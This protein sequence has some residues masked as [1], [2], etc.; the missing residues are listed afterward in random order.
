MKNNESF[1]YTYSAKEQ[2][3]IK[4]IREKYLPKEPNNME[5]LRR[6]D[7]SVTNKSTIASLV[8]GI[9]GTLIMGIGMCCCLVWTDYFV[10]GIIIGAV[11]IAVLSIAYPLYSYITKKERERIAPEI[12][13]LT[14]ELMK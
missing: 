3:E 11:G 1:I 4:K 10:A 9:I 7:K 13:R 14:D 8:A 12:I 6:L 2:E 5:R